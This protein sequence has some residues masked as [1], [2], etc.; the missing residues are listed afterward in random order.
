MRNSP[1]LSNQVIYCGS[2]I[3][4][5]EHEKGIIIHASNAKCRLSF[6]DEAIVRI[7]YSRTGDFEDFSYAIIQH[8]ANINFELH[9]TDTALW[10]D[11]SRIKISIEKNNLALSIFNHQ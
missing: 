5:E 7:N 9:E 3:S 6:Y 4:Y 1:L 8:E 2:Y 10:I 11:T